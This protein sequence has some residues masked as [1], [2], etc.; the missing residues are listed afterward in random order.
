MFSLEHFIWLGISVVIIVG[1]FFIYRKCKLSYDTVLNIMLVVSV[2]SETVKI[3]CNMEP[4][5]DGRTGKILDPGDLP[6]HLCSLQIF[7]MFAL[8]FFVKKE[9]TKEKCSA[10]CA[11][12]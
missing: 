7:L 5:P 8:K 11:L 10:L 6:F 3:L 9:D 12:R 1:M 2:A 4:A